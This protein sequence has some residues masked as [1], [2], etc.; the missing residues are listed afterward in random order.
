MI[1]LKSKVLVLRSFATH[2]RH[3]FYPSRCHI[4]RLK[5]TTMRTRS[6]HD[7]VVDDAIVTTVA[8]NSQVNQIAQNVN[9]I[10]RYGIQCSFK[11]L[12][13]VFLSLFRKR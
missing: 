8:A 12:Q 6:D 5:A 7:F 3:D 1:M 13:S 4:V 9:K 10:P 11:V 2:R